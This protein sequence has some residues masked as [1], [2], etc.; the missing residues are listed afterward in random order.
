M[1]SIAI[2]SD[3]HFEFHQGDA[4]WLPPLPATCDVLILAGDI[5]VGAGALEAVLKMAKALPNTQIVWV[6]GN[7]EFYRQSMETQLAY[8]RKECARLDRVHFLENERVDILGY[9]FLGCT[10]W[11]GFDCLGQEESY[12]RPGGTIFDQ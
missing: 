6:A 9:T 1:I 11:T 12:C 2:A 7:H 4:A 8:Y 3:L 10:L 5:G